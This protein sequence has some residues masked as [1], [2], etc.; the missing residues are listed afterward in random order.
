MT[1]L[2]E[3]SNRNITDVEAYQPVK[4]SYVDIPYVIIFLKGGTMML[5]LL[6]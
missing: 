4:L 5:K 2:R 6:I 1:V 3:A